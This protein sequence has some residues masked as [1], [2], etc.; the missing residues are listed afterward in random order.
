MLG[1]GSAVSQVTALAA[2][3]IE[4]LGRRRRGRVVIQRTVRGS[5]LQ[6][7]TYPSSSYRRQPCRPWRSCGWWP[8]L[9]AWCR[10]KGVRFSGKS[11][12]RRVLQKGPATA[13]DA[14]VSAGDEVGMFATE[15]RGRWWWLWARLVL[16][17]GRKRRASSGKGDGKSA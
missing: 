2:R 4:T 17:R 12:Q 3:S 11:C 7:K 8:S 15:S 1:S 9:W 5:W 13:I 16:A 10:L 14:K 6:T